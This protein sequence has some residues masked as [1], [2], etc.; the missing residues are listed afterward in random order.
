MDFVAILGQTSS[1]L[2]ADTFFHNNIDIK[3]WFMSKNVDITQK[4]ALLFG[5]WYSSDDNK[6]MSPEERIY[7]QNLYLEKLFNVEKI[8][9][10]K[11]LYKLEQMNV[12]DRKFIN[13]YQ[14]LVE[15]EDA[16]GV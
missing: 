6:H 15:K 10:Q 9:I 14:E 3:N 11:G 2:D 13:R 4:L 5:F 12:I 16:H 8:T 7:A 1:Y